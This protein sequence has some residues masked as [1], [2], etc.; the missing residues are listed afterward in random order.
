MRSYPAAKAEIPELEHVKHVF[1]RASAS[2]NNRAKT[3]INLPVNAS[4][5]C[6][7]FA[8]RN[9]PQVVLV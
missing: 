6:V 3:V 8:I 2:L 4:A 1:V 5:T 7:A 9:A